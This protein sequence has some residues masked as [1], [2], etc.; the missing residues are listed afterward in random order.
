M[1]DGRAPLTAE[2]FVVLRDLAMTAGEVLQRVVPGML[3]EAAATIEHGLNSEKSLALSPVARRKS[4][5]L[6]AVF[7]VAETLR[8]VCAKAAVTF[9]LVDPHEAGEETMQ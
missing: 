6:A 5:R 2:Q 8:D 3:D 7:R 4:E 9:D 1:P